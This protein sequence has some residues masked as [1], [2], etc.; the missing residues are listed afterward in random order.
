MQHLTAKELASSN[1]GS[2]LIVDI[3][4]SD[5]FNDWH[6]TGSQNINVYGDIWEGNLDIVKQKL[7]KLPKDKKIITVCNAGVTSQKASE[8]LSSLGYDTLV[9]EKGMMG[10]NALH[11]LVDVTNENDL[12]LKQIIRVGKGCLSYLIGSN[13]T[14]E[15]FIVDPSQF[16][17]EYTGLAKELGFT[18][19]GVIETH[20][21]ADHLSG[22]KALA[23]LTKT[24]YYVSGKDL[25]AKI[26]FIDLKDKKEITIGSNKIK[27]IE[28]PGHTDG[29]VCLLV[30]DKALLTG[31]TL[32]LDGVGR[33]DLGRN[34]EEVEKGAKALYSAL[35]KLKSLNKNLTIL[36]AHFTNYDKTPICEKLNELLSNNKPLKINSEEE[37]VIYIL[38]NIPMAPPNYE[39]I[40]HIN[41]S[42]IQVPLQEGEK[43]EFGPNRCASK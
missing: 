2:I 33:P 42:V 39:Q 14:K 27:I 38:S 34:K 31:D 8:L 41:T 5:K 11:Q 26:N 18:I 1:D 22:A 12:V 9:L 7:G 19:K 23:D 37:F 3:R 32:F 15:C 40:K 25:K 17:D 6:I 36:P 4:E 28:T 10:W 21:H 35:N 20:V 30:N 43:L 13:S 16:I 24:K 29:S